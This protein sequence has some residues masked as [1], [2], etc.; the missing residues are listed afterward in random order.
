MRSG[1]SRA[2]LESHTSPEQAEPT[3]ASELPM[4]MLPSATTGT[5][6]HAR[7]VRAELAIEGLSCPGC[8]ERVRE[9]LLR[10]PGVQRA[11]VNPTTHSATVAYDRTETSLLA[12]SRAI[13]SAG[14]QVGTATARLG[15]EGLH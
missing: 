6:E 4:E 1:R 15:I 13:R 8:A 12:I 11:I 7:T 14:Y 5:P 2:E 10:L 3:L 9:A